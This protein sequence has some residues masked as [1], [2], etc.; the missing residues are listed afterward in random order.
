MKSKQSSCPDA[1]EVLGH[2][3]PDTLVGPTRPGA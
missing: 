2:V 1:A 3:V